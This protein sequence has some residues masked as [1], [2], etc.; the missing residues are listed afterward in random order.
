[1]RKDFITFRSITPAQRGQKLLRDMGI[2]T[3]LQRTPGY[4]QDRGCGYCLRIATKDIP[5][6]VQALEHAGLHYSKIYT[7]GENRP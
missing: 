5:A 2:D 3:V 6:A 7:G 1:M 4:M